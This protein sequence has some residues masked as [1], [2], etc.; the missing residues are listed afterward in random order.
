MESY[1]QSDQSGQYL[2][3]SFK[4]HTCLITSTSNHKKWQKPFKSSTHSFSL[5]L[6]QITLLCSFQKWRDESRDDVINWFFSFQKWQDGCRIDVLD[7]FVPFKSGETRVAMMSSI[8]F[9][10]LKVARWWR[11]DVIN[12]FF[13]FLKVARWVS[14]WCH[15]LICSFQKWHDECHIDIFNWFIPFKFRL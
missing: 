9:F 12:W 7:W 11:I 13:S 6:G 14:H 2:S 3:S 4:W 1:C 15:Q 8:Y 10:F 5:S